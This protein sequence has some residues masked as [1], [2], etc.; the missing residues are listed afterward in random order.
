M[1]PI[2]NTDEIKSKISIKKKL[3]IDRIES[4]ESTDVNDQPDE[5]INDKEPIKNVDISIQEES[6]KTIVD[7]KKDDITDNFNIL[8]DITKI[9]TTKNKVF[10]ICLYNKVKHEFPFLKFLLK[11]ETSGKENMD[12]LSFTYQKKEN[13]ESEIV[14]Y[15][16]KINNDYNTETLIVNGFIHHGVTVIFVEY[17]GDNDIEL[18]KRK[19]KY[20]WSLSFEIISL[21]KVC[22][23]PVSKTVSSFFIKNSE[24]LYF[25]KNNQKLPIPIS[26]YFGNYYKNITYVANFGIKRESHKAPVGPFYYFS[27]YNKA[28]R[29]GGWKY[30]NSNLPSNVETDENERFYEGGIVRFAVF[31]DSIHSFINHPDDKPDESD[32]FKEL[33]EDEED[34]SFLLS[35]QTMR[36]HDGNWSKNND[37]AYIG[38]VKIL[39]TGKRISKHPVFV[40]KKFEQQYPLSYHKLDIESFPKQ[41]DS[42]RKDYYIQ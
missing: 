20:W 17:T 3:Q 42:N 36:D 4:T 14:D 10:H 26:L 11:K 30:V 28:I 29:Y 39:E 5:I 18:L 35:K 32:I 21:K 38:P 40:V 24:L 15:L 34:N 31:Y 7:S 23:F 13:I 41:F 19:D 16:N 37:C 25:N 9:K 8:E 27:E 1:L 33:L 6:E 12:F 2:R 22:N